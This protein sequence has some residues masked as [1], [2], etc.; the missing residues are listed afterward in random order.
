M[1]NKANYG[2]TERSSLLASPEP[3]VEPEDER[4]RSV[5]AFVW[6]TVEDL[7]AERPIEVI[8]AVALVVI[9]YVSAIVFYCAYE[10]WSILDTIYFA[11]VTL[12]T[13]GYGD[14]SPRDA[15]SKTFTCVFAF[16]AVGIIA[17]ALGIL[18]GALMDAEAL[19]KLQVEQESLKDRAGWIAVRS[20]FLIATILGFGAVIYQQLEDHSVID[21]IYWACITTTTIGYGDMVPKTSLG[22]MF[23]IF[24]CTVCT[25][26]VGQVLGSI[27]QIPLDLRRER[28]ERKIQEQLGDD[29]QEDE[30][31]ALAAEVHR[32]GFGAAGAGVT[33]AEFAVAMLV[34]IG[35]LEEVDVQKALK[36]FDKLDIEKDGVL[37]MKD[38]VHR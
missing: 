19:K 27:V 32:L 37:D 13:V 5:Q 11:T 14:I 9:Y 3:E 17:T 31:V 2:G 23:A 22:K 26:L 1:P 33:R 20:L 12:M 21:C 30:L 16:L 8:V 10:G 7:K 25:L 36:T 6:A 15:I 29:L 35:K 34:S 24:F 38:L 4:T 28:M 18:M